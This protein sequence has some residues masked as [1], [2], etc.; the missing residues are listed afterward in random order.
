MNL[1]AKNTARTRY[2]AFLVAFVLMF[3]MASMSMTPAFAAEG[4]GGMFDG[5]F[6]SHG[7]I[8]TTDEM[9]DPWTG[10]VTKYKGVITGVLGIL[11]MTMVVFMIIQITK[12]GAA[13]DNESSR[14]KAIMGIIT[15][16][17][18]TA[19]LGA[20]TIIVGFFWNMLTGG[21]TAA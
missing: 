8:V 2:V 9:R 1:V 12:L 17:I 13:G 18:A 11:T 10:I 14:R 20:S 5:L 6:D 21:G 19:L 16:G 15:T 4:S 3:C 7:N